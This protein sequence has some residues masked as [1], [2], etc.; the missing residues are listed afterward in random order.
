MPDD[1]STREPAPMAPEVPADDPAA[2]NVAGAAP[3]DEPVTP[4]IAD[5][6]STDEPAATDPAEAAAA[7]SPAESAA[8]SDADAALADELARSRVVASAEARRRRTIIVGIGVATAVAVSV[9]A[10][11]VH[12][13]VVRPAEPTVSHDGGA[14]IRAPEGPQIPSATASGVR[15]TGFVVDGAGL[16]VAGAEVSAE[17]ERGAP[18]RALSPVSRTGSG[19]AAPAGGS[20]TGGASDAAGAAAASDAGVPVVTSAPLTGADGRFV[21]DGLVAGRF[22]LR[23]TG[24]G[25]LPAELRYVPVPSDEARIVVARQV[26]IEGTVTDGGKP[27]VNASVGLRGDAIGGTIE[28]R[29]NVTGGFRFANLPEGRYQLFAWQE[30]LAARTVRVARLG[31][32]P[33]GPVELRLE[34]AAIVVGRVIDRGEGTGLA[35]AIELRPSGDDQAPRYAR[36]GDD[37][38]FRIEGVPNGRWIA[39]AF[40]PG[41][42]S[43]GGIELEAGRGIP[44]IALTRGGTISGRV[45]DGEGHPIAGA[46]VRSLTTGQSATEIS[47]EVD[48]DKL[49]RFSGRTAAP[50]PVSS[51]GALDADP[52]FIARGELGVMTGPIPSIP[53]PGAHVAQAAISIDPSLLGEPPALPADA[54]RASIWTTGADGTYRIRGF[55][56]TKVIVL[57]TA[58]GFAEA[59]SKQV[60]I[61]PGQ[62][63]TGI[64]LVLTP[65]TLIVGKVTDQHGAPVIGAQITATPTSAGGADAAGL[66]LDVFTDEVG[67][68][69]LGPVTGTVELHATAY[70]HG[71]V[72][73]TLELAPVRGAAP[74]E[75]REDLVLVVADAMV[76]GILEDTTGA[77]VAGAHLDVVGGAS[78]G[79]HAIAAADGTFSIDRLPA[80]RLR[81]HIEHP[82][83]PPDDVEV[84]AAADNQ[85]R[86]R[87]RIPLGGGIE[88][89][90]LDAA[91]GA[92]LPSITLTA[93]GPAN[94]L[95]E[96][97]TDKAGRWKLGSLK[98]GR[99]K[100]LVKQPGYL[101]QVRELDV[102]A[103]HAPGGTS[104]RDVHIDLARGALVGGTVRDAR[105][106]RVTAAH[107][108]VTAING[109]GPVCEA[110]TDRQGEF[111]IRD[112]PTGELDVIATKAGA[113]GATRTTVRPG[114]EVLSLALE[115][116]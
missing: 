72:K 14:A 31:A 33:F 2:S 40:V 111:R 65:G 98:P 91:S 70:G 110:D 90:L 20:G 82:A 4:K 75:R 83:Y 37:G 54:E 23:V 56:K 62:V 104:V 92:P 26:A 63:I 9:L 21:I 115:L 69:K 85:A 13:R 64:D 103:A 94:A 73:R 36:S 106:Q 102:P 39:D 89:A 30:A 18:D 58:S 60:A 50:V 16:P 76:A 80:G 5:P 29:T 6:G 84:V 12:P 28:M 71:E 61:E 8:S 27:V 109:A 74:A 88:G 24:T 44:E 22:R 99:W 100:I 46:T 55:G 51:P 67:E 87:L 66:V 7:D 68:Y 42:Q 47:A 81:L 45:L 3:A 114:D 53:P 105:G 52:Q 79:R 108:V 96:A 59:R 107:V 48:R 25:L 57:A 41:Y 95:A 112:C 19:S 113:R 34:A 35:A 101:A 116:R 97:S 93:S 77:A 49:R 10:I 11:A 38:V 17:L 86:A 78:D 32:G 1:K 15:L 43:P